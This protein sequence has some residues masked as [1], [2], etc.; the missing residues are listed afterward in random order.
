MSKTIN[1]VTVVGAGYMG[2]GI[3]QS[4]ALAG[5]TVQIADVDV[6]AALKGLERLLQEAQ[7]FEDQG[8]YKPWSSRASWPPSPSTRAPTRSSAPTPRPSRS[9]C[10][11]PR[12]STR[13]AS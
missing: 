8:L 3:A 9:R 10:W 4:L 6:A 13:N 11:P 5:F 7:E 1:S 2:G 12:S